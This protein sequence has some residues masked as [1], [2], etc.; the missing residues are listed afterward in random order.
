MKI[1]KTYD[2]DKEINPIKKAIRGRKQKDR[3]YRE[4]FLRVSELKILKTDL[5]K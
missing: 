5:K 2:V 4:P 1:K 3:K